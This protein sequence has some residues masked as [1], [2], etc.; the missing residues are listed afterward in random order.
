MMLTYIFVGQF[1]YFERQSM[2]AWLAER[3]ICTI[4]VR[5]LST[6]VGECNEKLL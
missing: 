4:L 1:F 6:T 3:I 2:H 5:P